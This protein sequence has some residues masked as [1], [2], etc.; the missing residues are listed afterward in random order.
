VIVV[1][2]VPGLLRSET[3]E[4][5]GE[6]PTVLVPLDP[7]DDQAYWQALCRWWEI[8][9]HLVIV[10]QDVLP[11]EGVVG[12]MLRCPEPWCVS[13]IPIYDPGPEGFSTMVDS[14]G[15]AKFSRSLLAQCP[16][17]A[18]DAYFPQGGDNAPP[19]TWKALD[20]R[21]GTVLRKKGWV[22]HRH[23]PS[24]HL[25]GEPVLEGG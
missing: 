25:H 1:P 10:E 18:F 8:H 9:D 23:R 20:A 7:A 11:A 19:G 3:A 22:H 6:R 13:P 17:A 2:F 12:E 14:L 16:G 5:A 21:L 4:W 15:C 24:R